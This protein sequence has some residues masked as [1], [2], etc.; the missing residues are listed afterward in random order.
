MR[1]R[2]IDLGMKLDPPNGPAN[3]LNG[4][5]RT[6]GSRS[7]DAEIRAEPNGLVKMTAE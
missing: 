1:I 3:K 6:S 7:Q 4:L 2:D 5:D